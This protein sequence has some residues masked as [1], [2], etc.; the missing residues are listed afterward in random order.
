MSAYSISYDINR[1]PI[2]EETGLE[3]SIQATS[4]DLLDLNGAPRANDWEPL[5]LKWAY[6]DQDE[7]NGFPDIALWR[8]GEYACS[9]KAFPILKN[10][11]GDACEFLP[12]I[13]SDEPWFAIHVLNTVDALDR[14]KTVFNYRENGK[15]NR[16]RRFKTLVLL[17]E[18]IDEAKLCHVKEAGLH[19]YCSEDVFKTIQ[20]SKLTGLEFH[21][22]ETS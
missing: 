19:T 13:V 16:I 10:V 7:A 1:Y 20:N 12:L 14:E 4:G 5:A 6:D 9:Q 2:L 8:A 22:R 21:E 11:L 3:L 17:K 18:V 15:I